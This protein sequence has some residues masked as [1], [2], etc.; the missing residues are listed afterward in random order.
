MRTHNNLNPWDCISAMQKSIRRGLE[1]EAMQFA[2]EMVYASKAMCTWCCN[3]LEIVSHE[4]IDTSSQPH[5]VPFVHTACT[6][7]KAQWKKDSY[8][9]SRLFVGNAIRIMCRANKSRE[10]DHFAGAV[11]LPIESKTVV[12]CVPDWAYDSHTIK[13]KRLQRGVQFFREVGSQLQ[14]PPTVADPYEDT[15]YAELYK[16]EATEFQQE[17]FDGNETA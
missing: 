5:I 10:G 12:P 4:D 3:R 16:L 6:Q 17:L 1:V 8:G 13:G 2:C 15:F 14:P 11:G 9:A 7:A